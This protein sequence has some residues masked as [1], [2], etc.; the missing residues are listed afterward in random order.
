LPTNKYSDVIKTNIEEPLVKFKI[1]VKKASAI[2]ETY[3]T[4][5]LMLVDRFN[6]ETSTTN[7][8]SVLLDKKVIYSDGD[9]SNPLVSNPAPIPVSTANFIKL[10]TYNE[11][12]FVNDTN[13]KLH[14]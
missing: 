2:V 11:I 7:S 12:G 13:M 4:N 14:L 1:E 3:E 6:S 9:K 8:Y 5:S 10:E